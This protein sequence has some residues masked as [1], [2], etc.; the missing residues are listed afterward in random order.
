MQVYLVGGAVRDQLLGHEVHERD[1]VVVGTTPQDMIKQGYRPVGKDFPVFLHPKT[2][3]EYALARTERKVA[4]GYKGFEF[5]ADPDVTLEQ[6]LIRR[7]L[8][9]NAMAMDDEGNIID[10]HGGQTDLN[11]KLL[12]HV[13]EAFAEDPVRILRVA[14]FASRLNDFKVHPN[15]KKLMKDMVNSGEV[16][17]LVSERVWKEFD[18]ALSEDHAERFFQVLEDCSALNILFPE[19]I[20]NYKQS[21][22]TLK[23]ASQKNADPLVRF[24]SLCHGLSVDAIKTLCDRLHTPREYRDISL[25]IAKQHQHYSNISSLNSDELLSLIETLDAFRR[26]QRLDH[27]LFACE[28]NDPKHKDNSKLLRL[29]YDAAKEVDPKTIA[30]RNKTGEEIK[31]DL[32]KARSEAIRLALK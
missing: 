13:S 23:R 29:A 27:Y 15:T 19:L 24:V 21:I 1:W 2:H 25:C 11:E 26:P 14:R 6:D 16:D 22:E 31:Q 5:Y 8:T 18:R 10:P 30:N 3:E 7:D 12:H 17:A 28:I 20:P 4:K 32:F 9:I